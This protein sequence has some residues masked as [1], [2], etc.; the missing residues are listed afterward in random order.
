MSSLFVLTS[1]MHVGSKLAL[2]PPRFT[3]DE[4]GTYSANKGQLWMWP[5]WLEFW[6]IVQELKPKYDELY[7]GFVG[8]FRDGTYFTEQSITTN[9]ATISKMVHA[10]LQP[11]KELKPDYTF[12]WRGSRAHSGNASF[13]D[14]LMADGLKNKLNVQPNPTTGQLA[15]WELNLWIED[16]LFDITHHV[17]MGRLPH[18]EGPS[19]ARAAKLLEANYGRKE[20]LPDIA[21]RGH[22]HRM[23]D[24][25]DIAPIRMITLPSWKFPDAFIMKL[26]QSRIPHFGGVIIEIDGG[27]KNVTKYKVSPRRQTAWKKKA[28]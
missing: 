16:V 14:E 15:S 10:V 18:T 27:I 7:F 1:D 17:S 8:E 28:S 12:V 24:T 20:R 25:G 5:R 22:Q 6:S 11:A 26:S 21:I 13:F 2:C 4:G 23:Y 3:L 9:E 19:I